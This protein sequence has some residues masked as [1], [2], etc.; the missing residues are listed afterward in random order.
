MFFVLKEV[1]VKFRFIVYTCGLHALLQGLR[2]VLL[3]H[4]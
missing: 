2:V 3:L 4:K 1:N